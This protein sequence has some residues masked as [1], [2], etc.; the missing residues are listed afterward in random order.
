MNIKTYLCISS[1]RLQNK[2]LIP[3][4]SVL[5]PHAI[6]T[7]GR[8]Q[9]QKVPKLCW[10]ISWYREQNSVLLV[11]SQ[12]EKR[13]LER[14]QFPYSAGGGNCKKTGHYQISNTLF[15]N[16]QINATTLTHLQYVTSSTRGA[17]GQKGA[18][19]TQHVSVSTYFKAM[20]T[21][22][23]RRLE[24]SN[25]RINCSITDYCLQY[26]KKNVFLSSRTA[27]SLGKSTPK[28]EKEEN[29]DKWTHTQSC[30]Q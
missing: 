14:E 1:E 10:K 5:S 17:W 6:N 22:R 19:K 30:F 7:C 8:K 2:D 13:I 27:F 25:V 15:N 29:T 16:H 12:G 21:S 23:H 9:S 28:A 20:L 3:R 18:Q 24:E 11:Q 26:W 4:D